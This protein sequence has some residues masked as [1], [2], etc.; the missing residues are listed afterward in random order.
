MNSKPPFSADLLA[1]VRRQ[2][3]LKWNGLHGASHWAR[4][5]ENG[6][7]LCDETPELR[8]DVVIHFALL[9]DACR[10]SD[11]HDG[12]HGPRA[13]VFARSLHG[14]H[15]HLDDEGMDLLVEAC[16]THTGGRIPAHP[17]VMA[18]WDSDRL[19]L[20]RIYGVQVRPQW[21]G[22][23]AARAT[24][25]WATAKAQERSFPWADAFAV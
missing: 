14:T 22:T 12:Q 19:D 18:C 5:L 23:A 3:R 2:Y 9:H 21:L 15:V 17:T 8:R 16:H 20:P 1:A 7:R 11:R 13:A 25:A 10:H 6:M 4:V 24:V